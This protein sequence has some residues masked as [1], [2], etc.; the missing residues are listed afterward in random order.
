MCSFIL[1]ISGY[2]DVSQLLPMFRE[3]E[4]TEIHP[5]LKDP[6]HH[7]DPYH[8][9]PRLCNVI[10]SFSAGEGRGRKKI[11]CKAGM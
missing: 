5:W 1:G 4:I 9:P 7:K 8:Q 6:Y 10:K 3:E 2:G 11:S